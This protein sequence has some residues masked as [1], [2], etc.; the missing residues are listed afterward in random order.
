MDL[1]RDFERDIEYDHLCE[2]VS[3]DQDMWDEMIEIVLDLICSSRKQRRICGRTPQ[4]EVFKQSVVW[5]THSC[6]GPGEVG[7][8]Q[9]AERVAFWPVERS[10]NGQKDIPF[11]C[12]LT[13]IFLEPEY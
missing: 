4:N 2:C 11:H 10:E 9:Q 13:S 8:S 7:N 6:V 12:L 5:P 3:Y 1:S